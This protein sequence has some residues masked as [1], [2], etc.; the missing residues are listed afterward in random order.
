MSGYV[1]C[2]QIVQYLSIIFLSF[3]GTF[4]LENAGISSCQTLY[5]PNTIHQ[6]GYCIVSRKFFV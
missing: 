3:F 5:Q 1:G 2:T 6:S 4:D